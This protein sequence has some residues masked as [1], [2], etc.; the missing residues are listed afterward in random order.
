MTT[1][2]TYQLPKANR[3][4]RKVFAFERAK[5][6]ENAVVILVFIMSVGKQVILVL[7]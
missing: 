6:I 7:A 4:K 1:Y 5:Q 3:Q 2:Y